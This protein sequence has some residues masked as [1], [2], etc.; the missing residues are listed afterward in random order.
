M[1]QLD[2]DHATLDRVLVRYL[3]QESFAEGESAAVAR[4]ALFGT[5]YCRG[6]PRHPHMMSRCRLA[7]RGFV[8]DEP[9]FS[10]DPFRWKRCD[11]DERLPEA[12]PLVGQSCRPCACHV[13]RPL[14]E[15]I[16]NFE[17]LDPPHHC[18]PSAGL[19]ICFSH[20]CTECGSK[21]H[22]NGTARPSTSNS[23]G[24]SCPTDLPLLSTLRI[25][26]NEL[27]LK[28]AA[29]RT[30]VENLTALR[31]PRRR[32]YRSILASSGFARYSKKR[33]VAWR[34]LRATP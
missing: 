9:G 11:V 22:D 12:A 2:G 7:L 32:Q 6:V 33:A 1:L 4:L 3:D 24:Y 5:I 14:H 30:R 31:S 18:T 34:N 23:C 27:A 19:Q 8:R 20:Q 26:D 28:L 13:V 21:R 10:K 29:T 16:R 15:A 25:I 17:H